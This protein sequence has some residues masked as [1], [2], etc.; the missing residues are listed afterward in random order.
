MTTAA[1]PKRRF[2]VKRWIVLACIILGAYLQF[3]PLPTIAPN[4]FL[5]GEKI[6]HPPVNIPIINQPLTNTLVATLL[7]DIVVLSLG[8]FIWRKV[9]SGDMVPRNFPAPHCNQEIHR[10]YRYFVEE[11]QVEQI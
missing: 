9:S 11:K 3:G 1:V 10:E 6:G 7:T 5:P 2:G 8:F 4:V